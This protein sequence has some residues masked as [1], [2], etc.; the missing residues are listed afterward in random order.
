MKSSMLQIK[1]VPNAPRDEVQ[2]WLGDSLKVRIHAPPTDGKANDRLCAFI[3]ENLSLPKGS[4]TL[5]SGSS[6][7]QKRLTINGL[8]EQE[9]RERLA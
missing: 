6:S 8:S 5:A 1:A 3:A 2:G 4:V 7:R 9:V